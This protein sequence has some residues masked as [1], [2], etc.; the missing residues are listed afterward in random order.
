MVD[1]KDRRIHGSRESYDAPHDVDGVRP[2]IQWGDKST[3]NN[4]HQTLKRL[5]RTHGPL[6]PA[7]ACCTAREL[8][9]GSPRHS[10]WRVT[11]TP[12]SMARQTL[13]RHR[14]APRSSPRQHS[15]CA[16]MHG[17]AQ[18]FRRA[19]AIGAAKS[20]RFEN[21]KPTVLDFKIVHKSVKILKK[22]LPCW[23]IWMAPRSPH[24]IFIVPRFFIQNTKGSYWYDSY[25]IIIGK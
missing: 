1:P 12:R 25:H 4:A 3:S 16:T 11:V 21:K 9:S 15:H 24:F 7:K 5:L 2:W 19:M 22:N 6:P 13:P 8:I 14:S 23:C 10:L 17:V 20:V 18:V